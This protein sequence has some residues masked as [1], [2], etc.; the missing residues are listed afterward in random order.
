MEIPT[1]AR[2]LKKDDF[3][4][5]PQEVA[6]I[7]AQLVPNTWKPERKDVRLIVGY[8]EQEFQL[9]V[10]P[11]VTTPLTRV[12]GKDTKDLIGRRVIIESI[13]LGEK[14]KGWKLTP[15]QATEEAVQ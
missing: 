11:S 14:K 2:F 8:Q 13:D 9:D 5:N 4:N 3:L 10:F 6:I 12:Y 15:I 1:E 7:D